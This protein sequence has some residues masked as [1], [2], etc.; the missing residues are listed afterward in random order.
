MAVHFVRRYRGEEPVT[1]L[2][3]ALEPI[4]QGTYGVLLFQEQ[5]LR[6]AR[7]VAGLSW[8]EAD[9]LRRGMSRFRSDEMDA[10]R[11]AFIA[12]C[13]RAAPNGPGFASKQAETL[14]DQVKA[15]AGYGFNQG[16]ATAYAGVSY[17]SA[18]LK[19]HWP[20]AFLCARLADWGGFY[21]QAVYIAEARRLGITVRPPHVNHGA[22]EFDLAYAPLPSG[23]AAGR[24]P[25]LWMGLSQVRDLRSSSIAALLAA[26]TVQPFA[27]LADLLQR[28][29]LQNKEAANLIRCGALDGLGSSR[30][31]LLAELK[32]SERGGLAQIGFAFL[33]EEGEEDTAAERLA[34]EEQLLG[35]PV[36][37]HPLVALPR[38]PECLTVSSFLAQVQAGEA[39][40]GRRG[41]GQLVTVAGARLPGWTGGAG[42]FLADEHSYVIAEGPRGQ[43]APRPWQPVEVAGRWEIDE[44]GGAKLQVE[45]LHVL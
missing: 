14:W 20:A 44:W 33:A 25:V 24:R 10:M 40:A 43:R 19:A 38:P 41:R 6:V 34:W 21:H 26:R 42:F 12:G 1:Y 37:V 17:R 27:D 36:S 28:V 31:A 32:R 23:A 45:T 2:H 9:H 39:A 35:L 3:A 8:E 18:Y 4:L 15:F 5:I 29:P 16:H 11:A 7:E 22:A 30:A 13:M